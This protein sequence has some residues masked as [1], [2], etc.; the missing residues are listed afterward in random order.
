MYIS[1]AVA[2]AKGGAGKTSLTAN[3]GF[4]L[5][6]AGH[7]V[8]LV[9]LDKQMSLTRVVFGPQELRQGHDVGDVIRG[10]LSI[11]DVVIKSIRPNLDLAP[12]KRGSTAGALDSVR[13]GDLEALFRL[14]SALEEVAEQY[15]WVLIDTPGEQGPA[16]EVALLA[17]DRVLIPLVPE[18]MCVDGATTTLDHIDHVRET[19]PELGVLGFV[20][21]K[22][23]G[24]ANVRVMMETL[25]R[26]IAG[27]RSIPVMRNKIPTEARFL[28]AEAVGMPVGEY[29]PSARTAIAYRALAEEVASMVRESLEAA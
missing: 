19:Y 24:N 4:A 26:E 11:A 6:N 21:M 3:L 13:A 18:R 12:A 14:R 23:G 28:E 10:E 1:L 8:L 29:D 16:M 20:F 22:T 17:A 25:A 2:H 9:D 15:D 7:R 5:S 27:E